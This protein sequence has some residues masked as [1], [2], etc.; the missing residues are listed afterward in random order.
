MGKQHQIGGDAAQC[1]YRN[2]G[3][4]FNLMVFLLV[5][6][7]MKLKNPRIHAGFSLFLNP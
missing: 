7:R 6:L 3:S 1:Q 2:S 5:L 4:L